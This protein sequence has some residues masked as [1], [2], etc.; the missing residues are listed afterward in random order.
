M[1]FIE[2]I[3]CRD[4]W[5]A[6]A[7]KYERETVGQALLRVDCIMYLAQEEGYETTSACTATVE[8]N[9]GIQ[10]IYFM[11]DYYAVKDAMLEAAA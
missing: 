3:L 6:G 9:G 8:I 5:D 11:A 4:R 2:V 1:K 10:Q 7:R